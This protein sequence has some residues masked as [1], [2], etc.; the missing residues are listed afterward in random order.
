[1]SKKYY[2]NYSPYYA[3]S[4]PRKAEG[5][6]RV[7]SKGGVVAKKWWSKRFIEILSSY[8]WANRLQRGRRYARSGQVLRINI[9]S[10]KI[11]AEVQGSMAKPYRV[12]IEFQEIDER[13]W[14]N[15]IDAMKK[16]PEFTSLLL[17]GELSPE[18]EELFEKS[19]SKLFPA[20]P[21]DIKMNCSCPDYANPCKHIAA[22]FYVMADAFD[23][24]PFILLQLRGKT[25]EQIL[26][27]FSEAHNEKH[28]ASGIAP[29]NGTGISRDF[30]D[31]FWRE[32][33]ITI[34]EIHQQSGSTIIPLK[35][36][37]PPSDFNDETITAIL[38]RYYEEI[39]KGLEKIN[40]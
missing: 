3:P 18:I 12:E 4:R 26:Q 34:S 25:Q 17:A 21:D 16:K 5:G 39:R 31:K 6:I 7:N 15:I 13:T 10:G 28:L 32:P 22:V 9:E 35:K 30:I 2:G 23:S 36:Y 40:R 33:A 27:A 19:G 37:P 14:N 20:K 38:N 1:M 24:D 29:S 8:G 11:S